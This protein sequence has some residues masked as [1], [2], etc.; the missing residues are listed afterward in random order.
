MGRT[1]G[2]GGGGSR[3][4]GGFSGGSRGSGGFSGGSRGSGGFSGGSGGVNRGGGSFGGGGSRGGGFGGGPNGGF[5]GGGYRPPPRPPR[6]PRRPFIFW[7]RPGYRGYGRYGGGGGGCGCSGIVCAISGVIILLVILLALLP[8]GMFGGGGNSNASISTSTVEREKLASGQVQ[9]TGYYTD[10]AGW[11]SN[12]KTLENGMKAFYSKTGVQPYLYLLQEDSITDTTEL[13]QKAETLYEELFQDEAHFLVVYCEDTR[14]QGFNIGVCYGAQ[15]KT[16]LDNEAISIFMDYMDY[17][18]SDM[19]L[20]DEQF[21]SNVF[22]KTATRIMTVTKS[23]WPTIVIAISV[24][25][26]VALLIWFWKKRKE[27]A[28]LEAKRAEEILKTPLEKFGD[29][30]VEDLAKKYEDKQ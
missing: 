10:E 28:D 19:S 3:G 12:A 27:Q 13:T 7:G 18:Y 5:G 1:G 24:V 17:Y 6:P 4:G 23:P 14:R 21:F 2:G 20:T 22:D 26:V 11:I 29:K 15:T 16:I 8:L 9:E 30:D 25:A